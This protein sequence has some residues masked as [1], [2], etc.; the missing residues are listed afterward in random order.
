MIKHLAT[1]FISQNCYACER[2]LTSQERWVCFSCLSHLQP[3]NYHISPQENELFYR[4]AGRVP[5]QGASSLYY[6]DKKG[7]LQTLIQ[8]LKYKGA[9][10]IGT[11][12]GEML[13]NSLLDSDFLSGVEVVI[14]IPLHRSKKMKRGYNQTEYIGKGFS[15]LSAIPMDTKLLRRRHRTQTQTKLSPSTR[16]ENVS[17]AFQ[18][19]KSCPKS[20]LLL[21]DVITTG[22]TIEASIR[23][24]LKGP[25]PPQEIKVVSIGMARN[26]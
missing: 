20:V 6:F 23:A 7:T 18:V 10:P 3:T 4:L 17:E 26:S 13:A 15:A 11:F 1:L 19:S 22:A 16:W 14:P 9:T 12:L 8:Q 25:L 21:D 5:V 24:L 2:A